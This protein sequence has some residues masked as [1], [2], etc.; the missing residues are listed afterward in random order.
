[1][2]GSAIPRAAAMMALLI[3]WRVIPM[4]AMAP[5][6]RAV[7]NDNRTPAGTMVGDTLLLR[8]SVTPAAWHLLGDSRPAF[9]VLAFAEEG[10]PPSV[11][12]PLIRVRVGTTV[13]VILRN[14]LDDTLVVSGMGLRGMRDTLT[15]LPGATREARYVAANAGTYQ[16]WGASAAATRQISPRVRATGLAR[17][18]HD[19]QLAGAIVVDPPGPVPPDRIF[20]FTL[21]NDRVPGVPPERD[22][23]GTP[24]REFTAIN[25]ASWPNGE[26]LRH[27]VGDSVRWRLVNASLVPHPMHLHG[28]Y[29]RVDSH[30]S[31]RAG[32]DTIYSPEQ[33]RMAVTEVV[34]V[35]D[36][37]TITWSPDRPG[38]WL[39]HCH[40]TPH[41]AKMPPVGQQKNVAFPAVHDHGDPNRHTEQGMNGMVLGIMVDGREAAANTVRPVQRLR[42][43]VQSD[44]RSADSVR[45]FGYVLQRDAEPRRDSVEA[46]GPVLVLTRGESTAI[47]V[48]NR[49]SE[50]TSV[51]WHG[52]ELDS[53]YDGA[54]GWGGD[55]RRTSPA[56]GP[57]ESFEVRITPRRAGTF[58]YHTHFDEMRQQFGGLVGALVVLEPGQ[59]W[60]PT[61]DL[62][63]VLGDGSTGQ[64]RTAMPNR[65]SINGS[66]DPPPIDLEVGRTYRIR[67]ADMALYRPN[68]HVQIVRD[69]TPVSWQALAKDGFELPVSQATIRPA[70]ARVASGETADFELTP[71]RPGELR[72]EVK[73]P[74]GPPQATLLLRVLPRGGK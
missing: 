43:F 28:F 17:V 9:D 14:P 60:D 26:R 11:P 58:M 41:V 22:R 62:V 68:V 18:G 64:Q 36:A 63:F 24:T 70:F 5:P 35:G 46:P 57:G 54:V 59:R 21:L 42:L 55:A 52:V 34:G 1:M 33:R 6:P 65:T 3:P 72:L 40:L 4:E 10:K 27:A 71:D 51:H 20:V 19:S 50:P 45:R 66:L 53:Y 12:G 15:L 67:I 73:A 13:R 74:L 38:G 29:F 39:F 32:A 7:L 31:M 56:V 23:Y 37:T 8:L 44:P 61:R 16:Y 2:A 30:G 47:E 25:G 69:S 48:V 49:T